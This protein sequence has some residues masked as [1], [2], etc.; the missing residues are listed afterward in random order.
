MNEKRKFIR[1]EHVVML[2]VIVALIGVIIFAA[3]FYRGQKRL[4]AKK[5]A[6]I[7]ADAVLESI[8]NVSSLSGA[9][10][11]YKGIATLYNE[12]DP[13]KIDCYV[14]YE[15]KINAGIDFSK[16]EVFPDA[17]NKVIT[18]KI[19]EIE[20]YAPVVEMGSLDFIFENK[21]SNVAGLSKR[22]YDACIEDAKTESRKE[23][24]IKTLAYENIKSMIKAIT[25]PV[26]KTSDGGFTPNII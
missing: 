20:I 23:E 8:K 4:E 2:F 13:E 22:A 5:N 14:Y 25:E 6:Q 12:K 1:I 17:E 10:A 7:T 16:I 24:S 15:A 19:P 26:L 21:K 11:G 18:V 9:A 3:G